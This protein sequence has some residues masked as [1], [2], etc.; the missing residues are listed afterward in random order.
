MSGVTSQGSKLRTVIPFTEWKDKW[1][2]LP[3]VVRIDP[4]A[5]NGLSKPSACDAVQIRSVSIA[6]FSRQMG[7]LETEVV[8][9]LRLLI[10][11]LVA[12]DI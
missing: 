1:V 11:I 3:F 8:E 9:E 4:T 2:R 6:R 10:G 12:P 7:Q 5:L